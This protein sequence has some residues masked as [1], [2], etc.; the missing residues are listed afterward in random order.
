[1]ATATYQLPAGVGS[2]QVADGTRFTG[3]AALGQ[4]SADTK[5]A[6]DLQNAGCFQVA[7]KS[8]VYAMIDPIASEL[9][10]VKAAAIAANGAI[11]IA[12]QPKFPTKLN[13]RQVV[14]TAITAGTLTLVGKDID[15]QDI[16]EVVSL[17]APSTQTLVT[18]NAFAKI[19]SGTVAGLVGGG[20]G[21]LGIGNGG[22]FGLPV[23]RGYV[24]GS[25]VVTKVLAAGND[26]T[27]ATVDGVARTTT[28]TTV[29]DG[30]KDYE[31]YYTYDVAA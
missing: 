24:P 22:A 14:V 15:G 23:D 11:V 21:T 30:S 3:S 16:T 13:I 7:K 1:M 27:V 31:I 25:L 9:V 8:E 12:A 5:Y 20:D 10:A 28:L 18:T 6:S 17:V 2:V 29:A 26:D 19:T 4:F